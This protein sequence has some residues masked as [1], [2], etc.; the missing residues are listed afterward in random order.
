MAQR[1]V[2]NAWHATA[3][4]V[5]SACAAASPR[6]APHCQVLASRRVQR[7]AA[8]I[9]FALVAIPLFVLL[10]FVVSMG[11]LFMVKQGITRAASEGARAVLDA[12]LA[13]RTV[14][15]WN[16][17]C[18]AAAAGSAASAMHSALGNIPQ[19]LSNGASATCRVTVTPNDPRC[20]LP[21][22]SVFTCAVVSV[23]FAATTYPILGL[24]PRMLSMMGST[25]ADNVL[26]Q[27]L[28]AEAAVPF[29][30]TAR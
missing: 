11:A 28:S 6:T 1:T 2:A 16:G 13:G 3:D 15:P 22:S 27:F 18:S 30:G 12:S 10:A 8:A 29:D 20:A 24:L 19:F 23:S 21:A 25:Q 4:R 26:S 5:M 9:E 17:A 14:L 7:G